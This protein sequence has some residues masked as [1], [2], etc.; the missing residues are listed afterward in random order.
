MFGGQSHSMPT[1]RQAKKRPPIVHLPYLKTHKCNWLRCKYYFLTPQELF[2]HIQKRH[3]E[4]LLTVSIFT[5]KWNNCDEFKLSQNELLGHIRETHLKYRGVRGEGR[6]EEESGTK[7]KLRNLQVENANLRTRLK[8]NEK[9]IFLLRNQ[10]ESNKSNLDDILNELA[11]CR[12]SIDIIQKQNRAYDDLARRE[13]AEEQ[14]RNI[15]EVYMDE[16]TMDNVFE[17]EARIKRN[18]EMDVEMSPPSS[19]VDLN[20]KGTF[21]CS[22]KNC[23][24]LFMDRAS[25]KAHVRWI[26]ISNSQLQS[27]ANQ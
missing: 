20:C 15:E 14:C 18:W 25:L 22:W 7:K 11:R 9:K 3:L 17:D 1:R 16:E 6:G 13:W 23:G 10:Y 24:Q 5:C 4:K 8:S 2:G 21:R 12:E 19:D 26:H 27:P